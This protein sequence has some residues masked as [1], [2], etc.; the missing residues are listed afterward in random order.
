MKI[1]LDT[2]TITCPNK[3]GELLRE[4][5]FTKDG[6]GCYQNFT[7][8][9]EFVLVNNKHAWRELLDGETIEYITYHHKDNPKIFVGWYWDGDGT[10]V[11]GDGDRI[12]INTDCKKS[13][14]WEWVT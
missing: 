3:F 11:I 6:Y 13:N 4:Q 1:T 14:R 12:V 5:F 7:L 8:I 9:P 10:L 2:A